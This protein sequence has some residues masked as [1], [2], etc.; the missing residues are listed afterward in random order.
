MLYNFLIGRSKKVTNKYGIVFFT[1]FVYFSSFPGKPEAC[2]FPP[3][4]LPPFLPV[5][6]IL[7]HPGSG[8]K[9]F[10]PSNSVRPFIFCLLFSVVRYPQTVLSPF[11]PCIFSATFFQIVTSSRFRSAFPVRISETGVEKTARGGKPTP[12]RQAHPPCYFLN[13]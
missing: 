1:M 12:H 13:C 3:V 10:P 4:F 7:F 5:R 11:S 8:R 6:R 9:H 2:I